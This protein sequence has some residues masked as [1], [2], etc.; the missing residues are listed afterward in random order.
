[1]PLPS[2][3]PR[4]GWCPERHDSRAR[5]EPGESAR[6][7]RNDPLQ[8]CEPGGAGIRGGAAGV[9]EAARAVLD[10][11]TSEHMS[12]APGSHQPAV[13]VVVMGAVGTDRARSKT[14]RPRRS[15]TGGIDFGQ[16]AG[17]VTT[18]RPTL[19]CPQPCMNAVAPMVK[20]N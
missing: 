14:G 12:D 2:A 13:L 9:D 19:R 1:M 20:I 4:T 17:Q 10:T 18:A 5:R 6:I 8:A 16:S 7:W 15:P 3:T 11:T